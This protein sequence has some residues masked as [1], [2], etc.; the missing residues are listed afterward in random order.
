MMFCSV[1]VSFFVEYFSSQQNKIGRENQMVQAD[2][3]TSQ[4]RWCVSFRDALFESRGP[5]Q[6][7]GLTREQQIVSFFIVLV[8]GEN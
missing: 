5:I 2:T 3:V 8:G 4:H 7:D 1:A 6:E